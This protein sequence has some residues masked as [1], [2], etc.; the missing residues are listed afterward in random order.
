MGVYYQFQND[1]LDN[2]T[3]NFK[4]YQDYIYIYV[5]KN[6]IQNNS[7]ITKQFNKISMFNKLIN[8]Y[9]TNFILLQVIKNLNW[10]NLSKKLDYLDYIYKNQNLIFYQNKL[11]KNLFNE[12]VDY[13]IKSIIS[14]YNNFYKLKSFSIFEKLIYSCGSR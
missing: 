7:I 3:Y 9:K 10:T 1:S 2:I 4:Y 8:I 6:I 12:N 13:K 5:I 11:N 14:K